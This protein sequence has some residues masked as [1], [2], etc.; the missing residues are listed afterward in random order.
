MIYTKHQGRDSHIEL[1][2]KIEDMTL[3][4]IGAKAF[5]SHKEIHKLTLPDTIEHIDDWAFAHMHNLQE[6]TLPA[7]YI[8]FGKKVFLDCNQLNQ[9]HTFPDYSNNPGLPYFL[10][11][12]VT[13]FSNMTLLDLVKASSKETHAQWMQI[14]DDQ[15]TSYL[16]TDDVVGFEPVFYGWFNDED[17]DVSQLPNY[18]RTQRQN[19]MRLTYL[20]LQYDLHLSDT[21]RDTLHRYLCSHMPWGDQAHVHTYIWDM[22]PV[23]YADNIIYPRIWEAAGILTSDTVPKLIAHLPDANPEVLAYLLR[24]QE[25]N[26]EFTDFFDNF[27]L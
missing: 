8:R 19:K 3:T 16:L 27:S 13:V 4:G 1:P 25:K 20:R 14:F 12:A 22:L 23:A 24:Y 6:I 26:T 7:R 18:L 9:I 11:A 17:A 10:A 15:L 5:L 21:N 2:A